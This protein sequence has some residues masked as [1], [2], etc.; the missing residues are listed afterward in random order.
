MRGYS[1]KN[2]ETKIA[3]NILWRDPRLK[4]W[5]WFEL[6]ICKY[7][8]HNTVVLQMSFSKV[9]GTKFLLSLNGNWLAK[10]QDNNEY[11]SKDEKKTHTK[12][13]YEKRL[14]KPNI[15]LQ[16]PRISRLNG[17]KDIYKPFSASLALTSQ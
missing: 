16:R 10:K 12:Y 14:S 15:L 8:V 17:W 11:L 6:K 7:S 2:I 4:F 1:Y 5:K 9:S 13:V 3:K